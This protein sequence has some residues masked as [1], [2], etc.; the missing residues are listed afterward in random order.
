MSI[1]PGTLE[2]SDTSVTSAFD[3]QRVGRRRD[4]IDRNEVE[5]VVHRRHRI[6]RVFHLG[7]V[8]ERHLADVQAV[9]RPPQPRGA[10]V[11]RQRGRRRLGHPLLVE[12]VRTGAAVDRQQVDVVGGVSAVLAAGVRVVDERLRVVGVGHLFVMRLGH[13]HVD[14]RGDR[15]S[16]LQQLRAAVGIQ[17]Q[18]LEL[19]AADVVLQIGGDLVRPQLLG[20]WHFS[21]AREVGPRPVGRL[22]VANRQ[23]RARGDVGVADRRRG[24][25]VPEVVSRR[26]GLRDPRSRASRT[27]R[28]TPA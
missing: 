10:G 4:R 12:E 5:R 24:E 18:V 8:G 21:R 2:Y 6:L 16:G 1:H 28:S 19:D 22:P 14:V 13:L 17:R 20:P 23:R 3:D 7:D 25:V 15:E 26:P 27:R 9:G 11:A